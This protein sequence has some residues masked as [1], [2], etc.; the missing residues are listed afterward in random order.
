M[1][2]VDIVQ[3]RLAGKCEVCNSTLPKHSI[4]CPMLAPMYNWTRADYSL[5]KPKTSPYHQ[6]DL[7]EDLN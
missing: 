2:E 6:M 5:T 7:F 1:D 3:A 4:H